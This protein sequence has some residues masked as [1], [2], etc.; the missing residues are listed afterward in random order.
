[1]LQVW[2]KLKVEGWLLKRSKKESQGL[3]DYLEI[4]ESPNL[5]MLQTFPP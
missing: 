4:L 2:P 3:R 1:M 5:G